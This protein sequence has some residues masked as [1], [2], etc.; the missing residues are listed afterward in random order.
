MQVDFNLLI[1]SDIFR[2]S[3]IADSIEEAETEE[4]VALQCMKLDA[5]SNAFGKIYA[6][7]E[8]STRDELRK[9]IDDAVNNE[10][11]EVALEVE[12]TEDI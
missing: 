5:L 4:D 12:G 1:N 11:V 10:E 2:M 3:R 7:V 9:E 8:R 6:K